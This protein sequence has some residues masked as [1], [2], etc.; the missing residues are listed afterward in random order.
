MI[1]IIASGG[2]IQIMRNCEPPSRA[3]KRWLTTYPSP[4]VAGRY[5]H[6]LLEVADRDPN[7]A[8]ALVPYFE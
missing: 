5:G 1:V 6:L 2:V 3:M 4:P 8:A 7:L